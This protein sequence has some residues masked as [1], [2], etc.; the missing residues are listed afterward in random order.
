MILRLELS[1][2][3]PDAEMSRTR[4]EIAAVYPSWLDNG[5]CQRKEQ[6]T[7]PCPPR[8]TGFPRL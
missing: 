7:H 4:D 6:C 3:A 5:C 2:Y 1:L 8:E